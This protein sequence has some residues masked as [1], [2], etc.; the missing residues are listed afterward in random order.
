MQDQFDAELSGSTWVGQA[1][2][3]PFSN[4]A[5]HRAVELRTVDLN[6]QIGGGAAGVE[7]T[8]QSII[9]QNGTRTGHAKLLRKI[10]MTFLSFIVPHPAPI[11]AL[12]N[13][14]QPAP[15]QVDARPHPKHDPETNE[16]PHQSFY[17]SH[18]RP[19]SN[20]RANQSKAKQDTH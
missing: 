19:C 10:K 11:K 6:L 9:R 15:E 7:R 16:D 12:V 4:V 18:T 2:Q 17:A 8:Q 14:N 20:L 3:R 1:V 5:E 13:L